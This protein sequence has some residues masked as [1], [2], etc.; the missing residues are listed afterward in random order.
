MTNGYHKGVDFH[1]EILKVKAP[2]EDE[3]RYQENHRSDNVKCHVDNR[4][5]AGIFVDADARKHRRYAGTDILSHN[6]RESHTIGYTARQRERLQDTDRCRRTLNNTR[7]HRADKHRNQRIAERYEDGCEGFAF[8]E[9]LHRVGH[10]GHT[11]HQDCKADKDRAHTLFL[12]AF[13]NHIK[14]YADK[15]KYCRKVFRL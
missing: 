15:G 9:G 7:E 14:Q 8:G 4:N 10:K 11:R 1:I 2:I 3:Q 13:G 12:F 5:L 6:N